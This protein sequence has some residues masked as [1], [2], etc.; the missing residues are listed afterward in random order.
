MGNF[1]VIFFLNPTFLNN[2]LRMTK[3]PYSNWGIKVDG[4][5]EFFYL[6]NLVRLSFWILKYSSRN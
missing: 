6:L 4:F 1:E 5:K 3:I 2:G